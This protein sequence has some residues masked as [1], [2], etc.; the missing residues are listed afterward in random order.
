GP[1]G[2]LPA[3]LRIA[4]FS[5]GARSYPPYKLQTCS[6]ESGAGLRGGQETDER[7]RGFCIGTRR[8]YA[9][10][11]GDDKPERL[12]YRSE[13]GQALVRRELGQTGVADLGA[14]VGDRLRHLVAAAK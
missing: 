1:P 6:L 12:R 14:A 4:S 5:S 3:D 13:H 8:R 10:H 11:I 7:T 2:G 9:R